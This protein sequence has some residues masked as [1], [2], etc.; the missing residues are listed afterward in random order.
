MVKLRVKSGISKLHIQSSNLYA[1]LCECI[2]EEEKHLE[3]PQPRWDE[4]RS[5]ALSSVVLAAAALES[6]INELYQ[7]AID[8]DRNA[9]ASLAHSQMEL[10]EVLWPEVERFPILRKYQ[11]ALSASGRQPMPNGKEPYQSASSLIVLRNALVHFKPEWDDELRAHLSLEQRLS[12]LFSASQLASKARGEMLWFPHKCLGAGCARWATDTA[13]RF[14]QEFC[15]LM[16]IP[17]RL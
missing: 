16:G 14:S 11:V 12:P 8:R 6:S 1:C 13:S 17:E 2:E 15:R 7:Q 4:A 3:W 9:L 5:Y 10:L